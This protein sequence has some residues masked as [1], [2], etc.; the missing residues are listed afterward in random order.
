[1]HPLNTPSPEFVAR[2]LF[3]PAKQPIEP[4]A[5]GGMP[6]TMT[7]LLVEGIEVSPWTVDG[8]PDDQFAQKHIAWAPIPVRAAYNAGHYTREHAVVLWDAMGVVFAGWD[9]LRR[10]WWKYE[11]ED[12]KLVDPVM[13]ALFWKPFREDVLVVARALEAAGVGRVVEVPTAER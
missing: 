5:Y 9:Y 4:D 6:P 13:A 7:H 1:M 3:V 10:C 12:D 8:R 11:D 2:I